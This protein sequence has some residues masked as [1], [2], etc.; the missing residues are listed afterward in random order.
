MNSCAYELFR[1]AIPQTKDVSGVSSPMELMTSLRPLLLLQIIQWATSLAS[2]SVSHIQP[3][4]DYSYKIPLNPRHS[5]IDQAPMSSRIQDCFDA[6]AALS[7]LLTSHNVPHAFSGAFLTVA[8]GAAPR[9]IEVCLH[10]HQQDRSYSFACTL[11]N[12]LCSP[13]IQGCTSSL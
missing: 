1:G 12:L 8:L 9:E 4:Y 7:A 11:G 5:P 10:F 13:W 3:Y 2:P 6:C